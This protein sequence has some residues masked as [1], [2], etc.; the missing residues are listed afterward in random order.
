MKNIIFFLV[1]VLAIF[2]QVS[3]FQKI[4]ILGVIPNL[5][6]VLVFLISFF[7]KDYKKTILSA[8]FL[9]ILFDI[10][11][12]MPFGIFTIIF[13]LLALVVSV[14]ISTLVSHEKT[15]MF[16][17][18]VF[19]GTFLY[20][21]LAFVFINIFHLLGLTDLSLALGSKLFE[22]AFFESLFNL[23]LAVLLFPT[24]RFI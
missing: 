14:L 7:S 17:V 1:L 12:G 5:P 9:G 18:V 3:L 11:S 8:F 13:V 15:S 19:L 6:L 16:F 10:F 22:S 2:L 21:I 4:G 23:I 20:Y 24:R